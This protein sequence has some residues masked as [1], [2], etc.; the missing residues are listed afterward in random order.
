MTSTLISNVPTDV[1]LVSEA[2][3]VVAR[4]LLLASLEALDAR[5]EPNCEAITGGV[6]DELFLERVRV[7]ALRD[8]LR[9][10]LDGVDATADDAA[11]ER[12]LAVVRSL[13][14]SQWE[15]HRAYTTAAR[16]YTC[17][18]SALVHTLRVQMQLTRIDRVGRCDRVAI[19]GAAGLNESQYDLHFAC[20]DGGT[21][22][23]LATASRD[24]TVILRW[25]SGS[26][27]GDCVPRG[28]VAYVP[29]LYDVLAASE[30]SMSYWGAA[31]AL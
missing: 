22:T 16:A 5:E 11:V 13:I 24:G 8:M 12:H 19:D 29:L 10:G 31:A 17:E 20:S 1:L 3:R 15:R 2:R 30:A 27:D 4:A 23:L 18:L 9:L 14:A 25:R 6:D 26:S 7:V 28:C 21:S